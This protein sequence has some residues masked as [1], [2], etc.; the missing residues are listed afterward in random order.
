M[1]VSSAILALSDRAQRT[2]RRRSRLWSPAVSKT[3]IIF[4]VVEIGIAFAE[5]L[6]DTLDEGPD[7]GA[8]P[9]FAV[10]GDEILAVDEVVDLAIADILPG[11]PGEQRDNLELGQGQIDRAPRPGRA[12][13]VEAQFEPPEMQRGLVRGLGLGRRAHPLGDQLQALQQ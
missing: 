3:G 1:I 4:D 7:I 2:R 13:G 11:P 5:L 10:T 8:I 9:L 12:A 6:A